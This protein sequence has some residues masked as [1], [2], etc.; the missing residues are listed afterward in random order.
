[1]H[2][3]ELGR[4]WPE[5]CMGSRQKLATV[6]LSS[7]CSVYASRCTEACVVSV[8]YDILYSA[9]VNALV[10]QRSRQGSEVLDAL[11]K[12]EVGRIGR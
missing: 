12:Q 7:C 11:T 10:R 3:R 8:L 1:M 9:Q 2:A 6:Y 4:R 5:Q